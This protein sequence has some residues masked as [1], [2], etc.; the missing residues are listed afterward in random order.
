MDTNNFMETFQ[1]AQMAQENQI[2]LCG[3]VL[4]IASIVFCCGGCLSVPVSILGSIFSFLGLQN[5]NKIPGQPRKQLAMIGLITSGV[6]FLLSV[7]GSIILFV[8]CIAEG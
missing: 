2:A 6:G 3:M 7:V 1:T 5:A 8:M 4:G